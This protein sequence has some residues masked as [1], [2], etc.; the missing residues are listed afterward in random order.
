[1]KTKEKVK[2]QIDEMDDQIRV[3]EAKADSANAE[4]KAKYNEQL[5]DMKAKRD[6]VKAKY[7][8]MADEAEYKWENAKQV[9]SSASEYF[10][11]GVNKLKSMFD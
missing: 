6:E 10:K 9:F 4:A 1:M 2:K 3:W 7:D 5:A 11:K 8:E